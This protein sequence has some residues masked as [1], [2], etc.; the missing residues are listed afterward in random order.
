MPELAHSL[1]LPFPPSLLLPVP[2]FRCRMR[3]AFVHKNYLFY[4][5]KHFKFHCSALFK[6]SKRCEEG[7]F[8][9]FLWPDDGSEAPNSG[10]KEHKSGTIEQKSGTNEHKS[11]TDEHI[12]GTEE[13]KNC[14]DEKMICV[15]EQA[16]NKYHQSDF[17][18]GR[19]SN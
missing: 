3:H 8:L 10:T 4:S 17:D 5:T 7:D 11:G 15:E 13:E 6:C 16:I 12:S 14:S 9:P 2:I 1:Q 18:S 19:I